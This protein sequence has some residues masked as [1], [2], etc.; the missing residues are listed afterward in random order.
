M[1]TSIVIE[2]EPKIAIPPSRS[3]LPPF[4]T[5]AKQP[6][7]ALRHLPNKITNKVIRGL[8]QL[9]MDNDCPRTILIFR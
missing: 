3:M 8:G 5:S 2:L 4:I 7:G 6:M 1:H 9:S